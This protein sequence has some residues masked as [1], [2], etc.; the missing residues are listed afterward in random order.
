MSGTVTMSGL[1]SNTN[2]TALIDDT[3]NA[4]KAYTINPLTDSK[5]KYQTKLTAW[6]SLNTKLSSVTDY[7]SSSQLHMSLGYKLFSSSLSSSDSTLDASSVLTASLGTVAG[8]GN[9]SIEVSALAKSEKIG[10]DTFTSSTTA[11]GLSGDLVVNGKKVNLAATDALKDVASKINGANAG[12]TA[13]I[14][15]V[16][17]TEF[18]LQLESNQ[19][20]AAGMVL[21]NGSSADLLEALNLKTSTQQFAHASG[22]DVASDNLSSTTTAVGSLMGLTAAESGTIQ[23]QGSDGVWQSVAVNLATDSLQTIADNINAAAPTDISASVETI[24][25]NGKTSYRLKLTDASGAPAT[26]D[27]QDDKNILE[28]MG[29]LRSTSKNPMQAGQDAAL[30]IDGYSITSSSNTLTNAISG[31]TLS[32]TGTNVGKPIKLTISQDS[33]QISQKATN[34]VTGLNNVLSFLSDQSTYTPSSDPSKAATVP[35][36]F[37]DINLNLVRGSISAAM[38]KAV[39]GNT[40]Y[41]TAS[42]IGISYNKDGKSISVD[43]TK[44]ANALANNK[45]ETLNVLQTLSKNLN[46]SLKAYVDPATGTFTLMTKSITNTMSKIDDHIDELNDRYDRQRTMLEQRYNALELLINQSNTTKSWLTQQVAA[47]K[48]SS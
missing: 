31:V 9:Y 5:N 29:L 22:S 6:Q 8:P 26:A 24:T 44:L 33:S 37:G 7:I 39:D 15:K 16:S 34:L 45:D 1:A 21:K 23:I 2:W 12:V 14:I 40:T 25:Q 35:A 4:Q 41:T 36:L 27:F 19:T 38:F 11:L 3:I 17:D 42:S 32:L 20:G 43:S 47:M 13:T 30:K 28:T 10:S 46:D 18:R 48:S